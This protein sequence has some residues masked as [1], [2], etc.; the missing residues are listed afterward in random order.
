MISVRGG[1]MLRG[2]VFAVLLC[3]GVTGAAAETFK[4]GLGLALEG[5]DSRAI[6]QLRDGFELGMRQANG[7]FGGRTVEIVKLPEGDAASLTTRMD[8]F[9]KQEAPAMMVLAPLAS[10]PMPMLKSLSDAGV[11]VVRP[12]QGG[13]E[14]AGKRCLANVFVVGWQSEQA[15]DV[16]GQFVDNSNYKRVVLVNSSSV[17]VSADVLR[18]NIKTEVLRQIVLDENAAD[19]DAEIKRLLLDSPQAVLLHTPT[20]VAAKFVKALRAQPDG[21]NIVIMTAA[22]SEESGLTAFGDAAEGLLAPGPW[23]NGLDN[24]VNV[25]FTTDFEKAFG[26]PPSSLAV[27]AYDSVQLIDAA[28]AT[29][30]GPMTP[31]ALRDA[32]HGTVLTSPRGQVAFSNNNFPIE[33]FY[34]KRIEAGKDGQ[35]RSVPVTKVFGQFGDDFAAECPLR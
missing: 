23:A 33:D 2:L 21:Q 35:Y 4:I 15:L 34:I 32:L 24:P 7:R 27:F 10:D 20:G 8:A 25:A 5:L 12:G 29:I 11:V 3:L 22:A 30:K 16:M 18:R 26:Y 1:V 28:L 13:T 14:L 9:V 31:K 19:Y 6:A 17:S